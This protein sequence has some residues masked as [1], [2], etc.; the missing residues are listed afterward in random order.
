[1]QTT[2]FEGILAELQTATA[3]IQDLSESFDRFT[4]P[5]IKVNHAFREEEHALQLFKEAAV[6]ETIERSLE[7]EE[8]GCSND[9][10]VELVLTFDDGSH[11]HDCL[12]PYTCPCKNIIV[13]V[14]DV[15]EDD[16][17]PSVVTKSFADIQGHQL[18]DL[19]FS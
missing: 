8:Q 19:F 9:E 3:W 13:A 1:M 12:K 18:V 6:F 10:D 11:C 4:V 16:E 15:K 5:K 2:S 7:C 14:D 17:V